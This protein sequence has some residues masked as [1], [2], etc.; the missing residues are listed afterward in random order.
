MTK[1][2]LDIQ[3]MLS[4]RKDKHANRVLRLVQ[5]LEKKEKAH[6]TQ[7]QKSR[8]LPTPNYDN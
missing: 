7:N 3:T 6:H 2:G 1:N 8:F 5:V 4:N